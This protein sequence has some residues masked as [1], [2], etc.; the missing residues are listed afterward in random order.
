MVSQFEKTGTVENL[1]KK[2]SLTAQKRGGALKAIKNALT[3]NPKLPI[4]KL[5]QVADC[6]YNMVRSILKDDLKLSSYK[7]HESH[8]LHE[9]DYEKRLEF[10][11]WFLKKLHKNTNQYL[12]CTDEAWFT[13]TPPVNKQNDRIWSRESPMELIERPLHGQKVMAFCALSSKKIYGVYFFEGNVNSQIYLHMLDKWFWKKHVNTVDWNKFIFQQDGA[14]PHTSNEVQEWLGKKFGGNFWS[15]EIWPPR[16]P[17]LNPCDY[18]LWGYLKSKVYNPIPQ[19]IDQ[20][21]NNIKREIQKISKKTLENVFE[22][23]KKRLRLVI[24]TEGG[25]IENI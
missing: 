1:P 12:I 22:N 2:K 15:K 14:R 4:R 5:M 20:L 17:D 10:A 6:S 18:F 8:L 16:S 7:I 23:F 3:E 21:K 24:S 19:T 9:P 25:H 11:T 13:L